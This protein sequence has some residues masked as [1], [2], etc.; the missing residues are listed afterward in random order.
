[1]NDPTS[2]S[3]A[4]P[5]VE[6]VLAIHRKQ[7][8]RY[9]G[10][11]GVRSMPALEASIASAF[12]GFGEEQFYPTVAEKSAR[13]AYEIITRHPFLD[14]NKRTAMD[15]MLTFYQSETG[16]RLMA[17]NEEILKLG[18]SVATNRTNY[19]EIVDFIR[20]HESRARHCAR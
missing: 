5:G 14:G 13:L 3:D 1:M 20:L 16:R 10:R 6:A 15:V 4:I 12:I 2:E 11:L 7:I 19:E 9:G 17:T 18:Y 8:Q